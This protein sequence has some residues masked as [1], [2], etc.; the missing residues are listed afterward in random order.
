MKVTAIQSR[1]LLPPKDDLYAHLDESLINVPERS[2]VAVSSKVVAIGEGRCVA[3]P[4]GVDPVEF[5]DALIMAE[6]ELYIPRDLTAEH[7]RIFTIINGILISSAGIDQSNGNGF[8]ILWPKDP[9]G[10]ARGIRTHLMKRHSLKEL[11]VIITDSRGAPLRNGV[12]GVTIGYA[13]FYAQRDYRGQPDIF[14]RLLKAERL[15]VA[16]SLAAVATLAMGEG[17]ERTPFVLMED[18]YSVS[19]TETESTD[20]LLALTISM[21]EDVFAPFI[22]NA[23]WQKG[24]G[25][26]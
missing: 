23:P 13:G 17:D 7:S 12:T 19:F 20:L 26:R 6:A 8:F 3:I 11:G 25:K 5:K 1:P 4:E 21:E 24:N 15:N 14:G 18:V 9:M 16:D 22:Q 2:V 10:S